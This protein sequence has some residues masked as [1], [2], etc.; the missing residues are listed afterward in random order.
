MLQATSPPPPV[1]SHRYTPL[2]A[3]AT[4]K[5]HSDTLSLDFD[6]TTSSDDESETLEPSYQ[7]YKTEE[8]K[9][10]QVHSSTTIISPPMA[11]S[12]YAAISMSYVNPKLA[13]KQPQPQPQKK[14][15]A[16][17]LAAQVQHILGS[18][19]DEIDD[20]IENEW[21]ISRTQLNQTLIHVPSISLTMTS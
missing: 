12:D 3:I 7:K 10:W 20:E 14:Q 17:S 19:F 5:R 1:P 13:K 4:P 2:P 16:L 8:H 18:T 11:A 21:Q 15:V 9:F 6:S